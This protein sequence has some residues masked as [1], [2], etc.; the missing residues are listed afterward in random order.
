M[1]LKS[2]TVE[3]LKELVKSVHH[4]IEER[5]L[6][7]GK[8][9]AKKFADLIQECPFTIACP[10]ADYDWTT[11]DTVFYDSESEEIKIR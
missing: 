2:M 7:E 1:N 5:N 11:V 4:E 3:E 9:W 10:D 6:E 8:K